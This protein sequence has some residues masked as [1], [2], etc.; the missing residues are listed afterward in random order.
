MSFMRWI[1]TLRQNWVGKKHPSV[2]FH[3]SKRLSLESLECRLAPTVNLAFTP[4]TGTLAIT[5]TSDGSGGLSNPIAE[6]ITV[7][8]NVVGSNTYVLVNGGTVNNPQT[9]QFLLA[10]EVQ[11][12]TISTG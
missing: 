9:S 6:D 10:S 1:R 7:S 11:V 12:L 3:F 8:T 5:G 2:P 4:G